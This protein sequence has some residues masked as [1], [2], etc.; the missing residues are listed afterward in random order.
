VPRACLNGRA[1]SG[2]DTT[3]TCATVTPAKPDAPV[4]GTH[5]LPTHWCPRRRA[6]PGDPPEQRADMPPD[7]QPA[8]LGA[9]LSSARQTDGGPNGCGP[10]GAG[11]YVY[12][13]RLWTRT[14]AI[15]AG[16][17]RR[18]PGRPGALW[19]AERY[20]MSCCQVVAPE[21]AGSMDKMQN[22]L[23]SGSASVIQPRPSGRRWSASCVVVVTFRRGR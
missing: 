7:A 19:I 11:P 18:F 3:A 20:G 21:R 17:A 9:R 14:P 15:A 1:G 6:R 10:A 5:D 8:A 16:R 4:A 13:S 22:S 2:H 23:P 12:A